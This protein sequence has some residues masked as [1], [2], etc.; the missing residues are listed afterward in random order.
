MQPKYA[1]PI[2]PVDLPTIGDHDV[3]DLIQPKNTLFDFF[4]AAMFWPFFT[5]SILVPITVIV[6]F[7]VDGISWLVTGQSIIP[8]GDY[9]IFQLIGKLF[10]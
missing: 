1:T 2:Q 10:G 7:V 5:L 6:A 4:R 3:D 8:E 9:N